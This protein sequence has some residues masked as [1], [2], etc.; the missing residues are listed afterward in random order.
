[1]QQPKKQDQATVPLPSSK[2]SSTR[3]TGAAPVQLPYLRSKSAALPQPPGVHVHLRRKPQTDEDNMLTMMQKEAP[4]PWSSAS[5]CTP[6]MRLVSASPSLVV[7]SS[8]AAARTIEANAQLLLPY[9]AAAH[10]PSPSSSSPLFKCDEERME[11][12]NPLDESIIGGAPPLSLVLCF[13]DD[14][15]WDNFPVEITD[16]QDLL[17]AAPFQLLRDNLGLSV[18]GCHR[19]RSKGSL[20]TGSSHTC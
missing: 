4:S 19:P 14:A 17:L 20:H 10:V 11:E 12:E 18:L 9:G 2:R 3:F 6:S 7:S 1:M 8:M 16:S 5:R 15:R 13:A